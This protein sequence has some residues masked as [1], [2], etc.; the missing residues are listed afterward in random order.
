MEICQQQLFWVSVTRMFT[1]RCTFEPVSFATTAC[2]LSSERSLAS[3]AGWLIGLLLTTL[4]PPPTPRSSFDPL[5]VS[6]NLSH[7]D[8]FLCRRVVPVFSYFSIGYLFYP[9]PVSFDRFLVP[10]EDIRS[11][12]GLTHRLKPAY[13]LLDL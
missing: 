3:P 9:R 12:V 11:R 10:D 2:H 6:V 4:R 7:V 1:P 8:T 13:H 5:F